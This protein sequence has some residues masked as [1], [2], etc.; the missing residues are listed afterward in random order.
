MTNLY[1][2]NSSP[3][4][5]P[6]PANSRFND[7]A[8]EKSTSQLHSRDF[9]PTPPLPQVAISNNNNNN[10]FKKKTTNLKRIYKRLQRLS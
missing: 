7:G 4:S 1:I 6:R 2:S 3:N 8:E 5:L 9:T 10:E